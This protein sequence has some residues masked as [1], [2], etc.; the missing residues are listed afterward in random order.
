MGLSFVS[1][2]IS[3]KDVPG[4]WSL[5]VFLPG[6]NFRCRHC[7]NWKLVV[8]EEEPSVFEREIL[9]EI[10]SNPVIDTLVISGGE[11]TV[12]NTQK[13]I[14]FIDRVRKRRP[15]L[16]I[17]ID[18]NGYNPSAL[19]ELKDFVDGFAVDVK[20]PIGNRVLYEYTTGVRSL[21]LGRIIKGVE[22][23]DGMPLTL[24]R[25]P[26]YP[27]LSE[28]DVLDIEVFTQGLVSPW[29]LNEFVEVPSCPFNL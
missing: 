8:G 6:C 24:F 18:T 10:S 3:S 26:K 7:H 14:A 4:S 5:V 11:P 15:D 20:S 17:R 2:T 13:L 19:R 16:R 29:T 9:S 12:H 22:I 28:K 23:A 21:E 27:W 25:T 1:Y